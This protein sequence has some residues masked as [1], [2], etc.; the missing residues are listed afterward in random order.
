M[1]TAKQVAYRYLVLGYHHQVEIAEQIGLKN[2]RN[3]PANEFG[4][5]LFK[6]AKENNKVPQLKELVRFYG[7]K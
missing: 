1:L 5:L 3:L 7:K 4:I 6:F 2:F